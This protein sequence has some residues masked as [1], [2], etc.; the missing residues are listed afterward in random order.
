MI[1]FDA[2]ANSCGD[3]RDLSVLNTFIFSTRTVNA[4]SVASPTFSNTFFV[5][6]KIKERKR[7]DMV[8][9][10]LKEITDFIVI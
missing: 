9:I 8:E 3:K 2:I 7:N 10:D 5:Y 4:V 1:V 6:S